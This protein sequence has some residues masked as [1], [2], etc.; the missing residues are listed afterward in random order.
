MPIVERGTNMEFGESAM[1]S[2]L[3][4]T[5]QSHGGLSQMLVK[6]YSNMIE[7][8]FA[9]EPS[10][11]CFCHLANHSSKLF[12][13]ASDDIITFLATSS[14]QGNDLATLGLHRDPLW[15]LWSG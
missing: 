13:A 3:R 1:C 2:I 15:R 14:S 6:F 8:I 12:A 7:T 10:I 11:Q 4:S 9:E 5:L